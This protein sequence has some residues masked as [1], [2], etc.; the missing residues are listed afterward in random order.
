MSYKV[1]DLYSASSLL[2]ASQYK[3][4]NIL[5]IIKSICGD[6][7][8]TLTLQGTLQNILDLPKTRF[9]A[10]A[11]GVQLDGIGDIVGLKRPDGYS[12]AL[13][14]Q[15]LIGAIV[16]S[17]SSGTMDDIYNAIDLAITY[18]LSD[19]IVPSIPFI[20]VERFPQSITVIIYAPS[21]NIA[22]QVTSAL[23]K[24]T[25][26][27]IGTTV[28]ATEYENNVFS[29]GGDLRSFILYLNGLPLLLN[30]T[31]NLEVTTV[32]EVQDE[33]QGFGYGQL[34]DIVYA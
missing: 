27:P 6:S 11:V 20:V 7:S 23:N 8:L 5:N 21:S 1:P 34:A 10:N 13:Y 16:G 30:S 22:G 12:D 18:D 14:R 4:N 29:F 17:K 33:E 3:K 9:I 19:D 2:L 32:Y 25:A 24:A 26:A 31:D 28:I 15:L